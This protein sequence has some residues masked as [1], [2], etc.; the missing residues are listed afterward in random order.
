MAQVTWAA[1][2]T[3]PPLLRHSRGEEALQAVAN[4]NSGCSVIFVVII[5][6]HGSKGVLSRS[7]FRRCACDSYVC[8]TRRCYRSSMLALRGAVPS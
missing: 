3:E 5:R 1:T 2:R 8:T 4:N 7:R 6:H